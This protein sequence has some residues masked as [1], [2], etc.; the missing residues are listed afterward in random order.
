MIHELRSYWAKPGKL[1]ALHDRFAQH[2]NRL[3]I[4]HG[5]TIVAFWTPDDTALLGDLVYILG[6]P[7]RASRDVLF[8]AFAADPE[9][10]AA[11]TASERDGSL[12]SK[13]TSVLLTP[14]PYSPIQ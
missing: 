12:V 4:K 6:Y 7:D 3:F 8:N 1:P 13:I 11:K 10:L 5:I 14:T 2:T 9:W